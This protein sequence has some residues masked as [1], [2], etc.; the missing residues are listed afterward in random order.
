MNT[1]V[2]YYSRTGHN[3]Q[4]AQQLHEQVPSD[5]DQIVD[6]K[7]RDSMPGSAFAAFFKRKTKITFAKD[8]GSYDQVIVVTPFWAG[9]LPPATRTYLR[10]HRANLK[11]FAI[12]SS[13]GRGEE[14]PN[15][16]ADV[17]AVAGQQPF[18]SLLIKEDE[19]ADE[20]TRQKFSAFV[21]QL[22]QPTLA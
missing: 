8:P 22:P 5:L 4:L 19:L 14:N 18:A 9:N 10:Q 21:E 16:L 3:E 15:A 7:K 12:L 13:C 11:K 17:T 2:A 6:T 1:L 20:A